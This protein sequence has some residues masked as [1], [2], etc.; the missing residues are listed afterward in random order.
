MCRFDSCRGTLFALSLY[1]QDERTAPNPRPINQ[2]RRRKFNNAK[3]DIIIKII[4]ITTVRDSAMGNR[5]NLSVL[6]VIYS[7]FFFETRSMFQKDYNYVIESPQQ[8]QKK[9]MIKLTNDW[10]S[11]AKNRKNRRDKSCAKKKI[12]SRASRA[13][14][15]ECHASSARRA[16]PF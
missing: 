16:T 13:S 10:S 12:I 11:G 1:K 2:D 5:L 4:I 3:R 15:R 6:F 14:R 8:Q 7:F 9:K